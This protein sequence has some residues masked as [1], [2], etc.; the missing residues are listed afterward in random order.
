MDCQSFIC[1]VSVSVRFFLLDYFLYAHIFFS[2]SSFPSCKLYCSRALWTKM[3]MN[4]FVGWLDSG[5]LGVGIISIQL[6]NPPLGNNL[7]ITPILIF[8]IKWRCGDVSSRPSKNFLG[9]ITPI[10]LDPWFADLRLVNGSFKR[11]MFCALTPCNWAISSN[12]R[13]Q[14]GMCKSSSYCLDL[15][16]GNK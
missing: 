14:E 6:G 13:G 3:V 1:F 5:T 15:R 2:F 8:I 4:S 9:V 12:S 7:C 16:G 10:S 11:T